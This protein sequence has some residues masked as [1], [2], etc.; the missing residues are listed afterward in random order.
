MSLSGRVS[1]LWM[2]LLIAGPAFGGHMVPPVEMERLIRAEA[3]DDSAVVRIT[4]LYDNM[5]HDSRCTTAWGYAALIER[6]SHVYLFDTGGD[7]PTLVSNMR[8]LGVQLQRV[9]AIVL[10]HAHGDHTGGLIELL[11]SG[12]DA[13]VYLLPS[14]PDELKNEVAHWTQAIEV[15]PGQAVGDGVYVTGEVAGVVPEQALVVTTDSGLVVVTGCAHP[16]V[17][18]LVARAKGLRGEPVHLVMGGFH[19]RSAGSEQVRS[20]IAEL[21]RLGVARVAPSHCTGDDAIALFRAQYG[22]G[23][24]ESGVGRV[25][26]VTGAG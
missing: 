9:E 20:V 1:W 18:A 11:R 12:V 26:L 21:Q 2:V 19:L 24:V 8:E 15:A 6:G 25:V 14:F 22:A 23:F 5:P 17:V 10:S 4:V 16:G 3:G 7:G 13:P